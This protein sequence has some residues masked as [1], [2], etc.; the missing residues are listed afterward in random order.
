MLAPVIVNVADPLTHLTEGSK[1]FIPQ[2]RRVNDDNP[3]VIPS[4]TSGGK[5]HHVLSPA[6]LWAQRLVGASSWHRDAMVQES[7][8][9][10]S[11]QEGDVLHIPGC[12]ADVCA[13]WVKRATG[14]QGAKPR[15]PR[16]EG[17]VAWSPA[18]N[19]GKLP[20]STVLTRLGPWQECVKETDLLGK[21]CLLLFIS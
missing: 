6:I 1:A 4:K 11:N 16:W 3:G 8:L 18:P 7:C 20:V 19:R 17:K 21:F 15:V 14:L 13:V 2:S 9:S 10:P 5:I 12:S